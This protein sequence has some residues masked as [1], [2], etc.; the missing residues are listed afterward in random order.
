MT[1]LPVAL[2]PFRLLDRLTGRA[3]N[4]A[5]RTAHV[6]AAGVLLGGHAFGVE[7]NRL[8]APLYFTLATGAAMVASEAGPRA[9][10]FHQLRGLMTF[11]KLLLVASV[12]V[13]WDWRLPIL[14]AV[15]V[16]ASVG[17]HMPAR[18]RYYSV[19]YR[20]VV[21]DGCG[22]GTSRLEGPEE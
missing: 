5:F 15:V 6:V 19:L 20:R 12:A 9:V 14:L 8:L 1:N 16:L 3:W 18:F 21:R 17:S 22:P 13:L 7:R 11:A 10:W 4:I 2:S